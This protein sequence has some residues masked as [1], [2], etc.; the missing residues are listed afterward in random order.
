MKTD[1][2]V[3]GVAL[4]RNHARIDLLGV[5]DEPG[6]AAR[7]FNALGTAGIS[8]DMIIQGVPGDGSS[9]QQMAF[10]TNKDGVKDAID[11]LEP[12]LAEI[13]GRVQADE[14]I[15]KLSVVGIAIGSTPG[16]AGKVFEAVSSVGANIEMITTSEVRV[17]VVIPDERAT[18]ALKAVHAM[19]NL[20]D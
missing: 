1:N 11:A 2:P 6:V 18:E 14:A 15:A 9:R 4:D 8:A 20:E 7:V 10:T 16:I 3:T 19:F 5:P 12:I 13:G 17:S